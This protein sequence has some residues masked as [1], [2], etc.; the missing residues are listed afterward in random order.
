M[1]FGP[2]R[3]CRSAYLVSIRSEASGGRGM[4]ASTAGWSRTCTC[5]SAGA[6]RAGATSPSSSSL[7][8][9]GTTPT[10]SCSRGG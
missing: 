5:R 3:T 7:S 10:P 8:R 6:R 2:S 9:C 1:G 4:R